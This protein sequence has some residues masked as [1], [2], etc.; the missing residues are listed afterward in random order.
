MNLDFAGQRFTVLPERAL[1]WDRT[2][3]VADLHLGKSAVFRARGVPVPA[4][5]C[6]ADLARLDA[7]LGRHAVERLLI[8]GD[9]F[10]AAEAMTDDALRPLRAWRADRAALP[11]TLVR[12]NHD[13]K[14]GQTPADLR[15]EIVEET[16]TEAGIDFAHEPVEQP[17]RPRVCGHLHPVVRLS[18]FDG[19]TVRTPALI[20]D[21]EQMILP[22]FGSFTGGC[23][24]EPRAD[25]TRYAI[26][27]G[28]VVR[29]LDR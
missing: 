24:M 11:V 26:A 29:M 20:V 7:L 14:S 6:E 23:A 22:A 15:F 4:G 17:P 21:R 9:L 28:R 12:G 2:L 13:R 8:L 1:L 27:A 25:R 18:D 16:W 3:V 19:S 5:S 10:H